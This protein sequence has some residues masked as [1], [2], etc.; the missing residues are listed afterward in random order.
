[1]RYPV[2][3]PRKV[4]VLEQQPRLLYLA[5]P[6]MLRLFRFSG[7]ASC[8]HRHGVSEAYPDRGPVTV[9]AVAGHI[10][11]EAAL[12][13]SMQAPT[14]AAW[15]CSPRSGAPT[16]GAFYLHVRAWL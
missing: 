6:E 1:M 14:P 10:S 13:G 16:V 7:L 3:C 11:I 4:R 8:R 5:L 2:G 9:S 15:R 12:L